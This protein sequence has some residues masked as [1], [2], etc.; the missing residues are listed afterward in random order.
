MNDLNYHDL[1]FALLRCP[2]PLL[3]LMKSS[4]WCGKVFVGGGFLRAVISREPVNDV[5]VFCPDAQTAEKL[6]RELVIAQKRLPKSN[7]AAE[8]QH[9]SDEINRAIYKT[10]NAYT[11]RCL[12]PCVQ[13]IHRWS[14]KE[15]RDVAL[16]FDFT[17]CRAVFWY[18]GHAWQSFCDSRFYQDLAAKRLRYCSPIRVEE[19]GGSMLRVLKYYQKGYRIPIDHLAAVIARCVGGLDPEKIAAR[20]SSGMRCL[21]EKQVA[22]VVTGLLR[23][24]DP[25]IDPSHVAHLPAENINDILPDDNGND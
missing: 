9:K 17:V 4:E 1:Q 8:A 15:G 12:N 6:A 11:L 23:E 14:F 2:R 16:S 21:D 5:D 22:K 25:N 20:D 24:V 3:R 10:D 13:I 7:S 19:A 18:D